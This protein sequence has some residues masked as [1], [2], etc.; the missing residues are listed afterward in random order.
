MTAGVYWIHCRAN[1]S[2]YV[3][4]SAHV[5]ARLKKHIHALSRG[6]HENH[7]LQACWSKYGRENFE[8]RQLWAVDAEVVD[9]LNRC[10][11]SQ[12]TQ[13]MESTIGAAMATEGMSLL[14]IKP[15]EHWGDANPSTNPSV[16]E[17]QSRAAKS[18]WADPAKRAEMSAKMRGDLPLTPRIKRGAPSAESLSKALRIRWEDPA[19]RARMSVGQSGEKSP[20]ARK[21][22]CIETGEVFISVTAAAAASGND[23]SLIVRAIKVGY[24]CGGSYWEYA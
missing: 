2:Y 6:A 7:R 22:R 11:L 23:K 16:N 10:Q 13:W 14:N 8:F 15:L 5:N 12:V 19:F 24:R 18:R 21:V 3:G 17:A 1:D 9:T 4:E 20:V